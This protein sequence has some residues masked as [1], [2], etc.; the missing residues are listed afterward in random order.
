M[1]TCPAFALQSFRTNV[2]VQF[3]SAR[4]RGRSPFDWV[5]HEQL[6]SPRL[7]LHFIVTLYSPLAG[8]REYLRQE[9]VICPILPAIY[10]R[11]GMYEIVHSPE[12]RTLQCPLPLSVQYI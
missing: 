9:E 8:R 2:L 5:I 10:R 11:V 3:S 7:L 4:Q 6:L 12:Y 1:G